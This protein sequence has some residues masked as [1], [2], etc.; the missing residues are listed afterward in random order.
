MKP[1][2]LTHDNRNNK[3]PMTNHELLHRYLSL[4]HALGS[5]IQAWLQRQTQINVTFITTKLGKGKVPVLNSIKK[6]QKTE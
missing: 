5:T 2:L 3:S 1:K 6:L 4:N